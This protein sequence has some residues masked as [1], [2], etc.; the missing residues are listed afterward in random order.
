MADLADLQHE[1]GDCGNSLEE[2]VLLRVEHAVERFTELD[3]LRLH[4]KEQRELINKLLHVC[5]II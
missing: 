2:L 1:T 3:E 5:L 4:K